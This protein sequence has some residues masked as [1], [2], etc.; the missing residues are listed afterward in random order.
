MIVLFKYCL[1]LKILNCN[2]IV[3]ALAKYCNMI[4]V[5]L[6]RKQVIN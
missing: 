2:E 1:N 4:A 3:T 5:P 6:H